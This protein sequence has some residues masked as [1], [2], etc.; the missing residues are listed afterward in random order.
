MKQVAC[1]R[2]GCSNFVIDPVERGSLACCSQNCAQVVF[3][4]LQVST[5]VAPAPEGPVIGPLAGLRP[6]MMMV[7]DRT[8]GAATYGKPVDVGQVSFHAW[9][10][11]IE[12]GIGSYST[13]IV[14]LTDGSV[15]TH[16][17]HLIRFLDREP[18][19]S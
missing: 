12:D 9:G 14:E 13:A 6:V 3:H 7:I 5:V 1:G 10:M 17:A 4:T 19:S 2:P 11:D 16:P 8:P 15:R 18:V